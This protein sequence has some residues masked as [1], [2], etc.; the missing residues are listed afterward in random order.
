[1]IVI[2]SGSACSVRKAR[3]TCSNRDVVQSSCAS[4]STMKLLL[5]IGDIYNVQMVQVRFVQHA[6]SCQA[7][8]AELTGMI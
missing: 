8:R 2:H 7:K 3:T 1:M 5:H 6:Y 4:D